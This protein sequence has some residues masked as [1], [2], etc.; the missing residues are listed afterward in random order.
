M[1]RLL[2][3]LAVMALPGRARATP[4]IDLWDGGMVFTGSTEGHVSSIVRNP[5]AIGLMHGFHFYSETHA[6]VDRVGIDRA[7]FS[8][9]TGAVGPGIDPAATSD[10]LVRPGG[11]IGFVFDPVED[12]F[13]FGLA[14]HIPFSDQQADGDALRYYARGGYLR[15]YTA[16]VALSYHYSSW[17]FGGNASLQ[18]TF[19]AQRFA[20]DEH[21]ETCASP[22]CDVED[23]DGATRVDMAVSTGY[24]HP[25]FTFNVGLLW[26]PTN[27]VWIGAAYHSSPGLFG[28]LA[29]TGAGKVEPAPETGIGTSLGD[30]QVNLRL[31]QWLELGLRMDLVPQ[32]WQLVANV[33][34]IDLSVVSQLD[35]R[36]A[37]PALRAAGVK[38]WILRE[39]GLRDAF[40]GE[41]GVEN[42]S[43]M[44]RFGARLM[45]DSG[46]IAAGAI[47]PAHVDGPTFGVEA[48]LELGLAS[49]FAVTIAAYGGLML[50]RKVSPGAYL[51]QEQ[52]DCVQSHFNL[53]ACSASRAGYAIPTAAGSYTRATFGLLVGL[54]WDR[55]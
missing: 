14:V 1:K 22:P 52:I 25:T 35:L 26:L 30:A 45:A 41:L 10:T 13:S 3:L 47:N 39:Q 37:G 16:S 40:V 54:A 12:K 8:P 36:L 51:P 9:S 24:A 27:G 31:P 55:L 2:V 17:Y 42:P 53:D 7:S 15:A 28:A 50:P 43:G 34:W 6:A 48:G 20:L 5:A 49:G 11:F 23:A 44:V 19:G 18:T 21:L 33:R 29:L 46:G 4:Y 32:R 38:E